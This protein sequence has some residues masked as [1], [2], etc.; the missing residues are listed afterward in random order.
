VGQA[1]SFWKLERVNRRRTAA[2]VVKLILL[3]AAFGLGLDFLF[4]NVRL[5][6]GRLS[7]IPWFAAGAV[8]IAVAQS[9]RAYFDGA[10]IV[11]GALGAHPISSDQPKNQVVIDVVHEMALAAR[12]PQPRI[13]VIDDPSP[14]AFAIGRDPEHSVICV[15][16]G[17]LD[18]MDREELQ[19]VIGHEMA[20]IRNYDT[21][22][23][24]MVTAMVRGFGVFSGRFISILLSREREYLADASAVEFTRNP[25]A[26]LRALQQIAKTES[27]LRCAT[28]GTAQLFIVDPLQSASGGGGRS[29]E[30]FINEITRIRLQ[31]DKTEA[32]RD[33]EA[34]NFAAHEYPRNFVLER[35]SSH[36][37]L[38]D[39]IARLQTLAGEAPAAAQASGI[40]DDQLKAKFKESVLFLRDAASTDP[41]VLA[42][43]MQAA[44][45]ASPVGR[46]FLQ[47]TIGTPPTDQSAPRDPIEQTLYQADLA[48][49]GDLPRDPLEQKLYEANLASTGD[50]QRSLGPAQERYELR[51]AAAEDF[52]PS[53]F[54]LK[55]QLLAPALAS[56]RASMVNAGGNSSL[57]ADPASSKGIGESN[58]AAKE[59]LERE[60]L[61]KFFAPVAASMRPKKAATR[62][63]AAQRAS[64]SRGMLLFWLVIAVSAGTIVAALA[65]R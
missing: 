18:Q 9:M 46:E 55:E 52:D 33:A 34:K 12:M 53:R 62:P 51:Q 15:T 65:I 58:P 40:S 48:S 3:L 7:G 36:P 27:P 6:D 20:H 59:E 60:A 11:L 61:A 35:I 4:H 10:D 38:R 19:G 13:N 64:G 29:Y 50:L 14:N 17:L 21:R 26:L 39:R 8:F 22:L 47:A 1:G 30:E 49:T 23:T 44:L 24:T 43:T 28:P 45:L 5:S 32:Q 25:K 56:L 41:E 31:P 2:L 57:N 63:A 16:Q 54:S 42:K 37:P